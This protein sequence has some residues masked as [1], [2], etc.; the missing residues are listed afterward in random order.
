MLLCCVI[1]RKFI[2]REN[3]W[4]DNN[5][6]EL[7]IIIKKLKKHRN[8]KLAQKDLDEI[9]EISHLQLDSL[10]TKRS[11]LIN[12]LNQSKKVNLERVRNKF[13]KRSYDY[14]VK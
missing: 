2:N 10:K 5:E 9:L 6:N 11:Q 12:T 4:G 3:F 14:L 7:S 8:S 1:F 13:D